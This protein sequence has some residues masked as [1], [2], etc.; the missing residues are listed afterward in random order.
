MHQH[1]EGSD[2]AILLTDGAGCVTAIDV[3]NS[4]DTYGPRDQVVGY[5]SYVIN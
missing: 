5:G 2:S 4:G 1:M 3:R